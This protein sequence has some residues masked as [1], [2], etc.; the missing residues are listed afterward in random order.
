MVWLLL[1][2]LFMEI[3]FGIESI[4]VELFFLMDEDLYEFSFFFV[5]FDDVI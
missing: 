5:V 3:V 2:V 1:G 4:I